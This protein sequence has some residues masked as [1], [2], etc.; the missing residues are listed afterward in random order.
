M[1]DYKIEDC[2]MKIS[3]LPKDEAMKL[4][5]TWIK[6]DYINLKQFKELIISID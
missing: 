2:K 1:L 5:F 4:I 3:K 6:Q